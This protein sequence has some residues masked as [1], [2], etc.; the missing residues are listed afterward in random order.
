MKNMYEIIS[1]IGK[2][3]TGNVYK[4]EDKRTKKKYALK[5][6]TSP[7]YS[8]IIKNEISVYE[9]L[10]NQH[11]FIVNYYKHYE[12]ED[13][14]NQTIL[15]M[16]LENCEHGSCIDIIF[17]SKDKSNNLFF[18]KNYPFSEKEI[19]CIIYMLLKGLSFLHEKNYIHRDIKARNILINSKGEA[20]LCDFGICRQYIKG[21]MHKAPRVGSPYWMAPEVINREE[22]D[23]SSDIWS[24][25]ITVLELLDGYPPFCDLA[26]KEVMKEI[27][28]KP[29]LEKYTN[30]LEE[31]NCSKE[32]I[33]FVLKC[34]DYNKNNRPSAKELLEHKFLALDKVK[35]RSDIIADFLRING[36]LSE[37]ESTVKCSDKYKSSCMCLDDEETIYNNESFYF[38]YNNNNPYNKHNEYDNINRNI[39][40]KKPPDKEIKIIKTKTNKE[41]NYPLH[42]EIITYN[43]NPLSKSSIHPKQLQLNK[44]PIIKRRKTEN[45]VSPPNLFKNTKQ[46]NNQ[47]ILSNSNND[48][49]N[50]FRETTKDS[51]NDYIEREAK[52]F[53]LIQRVRENAK[54]KEEI[55]KKVDNLI[56]ERDYKINEI[57]LSYDIKISKYKNALKILESDSHVKTLKEFKLKRISR[58]NHRMLNKK[59]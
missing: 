56:N 58:D 45:S 39:N 55:Q 25:G 14:N 22:F 29:N 9:S 49:S 57:T 7:K 4:V 42:E 51:F 38:E 52:D 32:L 10:K 8:N 40:I 43:L 34:L 36:F 19:S 24:V 5:Q 12:S 2:G 27:V 16:I 41:Y 37:R 31:Y 15:N 48:K 47:T 35:A 17:Y 21:E 6:S 54:K 59:G 1:Y 3:S 18:Q 44:T 23:F 46:T 28:K 13:S 20:K 33:D 11:D 26:P 53:V 30:I 50:C